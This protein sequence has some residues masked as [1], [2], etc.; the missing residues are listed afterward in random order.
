MAQPR[1]LTGHPLT[2]SA[3]KGGEGGAQ[4]EALGG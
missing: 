3:L 4:R 2:L 1:S